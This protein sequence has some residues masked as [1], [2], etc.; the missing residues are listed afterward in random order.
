MGNSPN[1][2]KKRFPW[3]WAI[4]LALGI[5]AGAFTWVQKHAPIALAVGALGSWGFQHKQRAD[6][7]AAAV[8]QR[9]LELRNLAK[10]AAPVQAKAAQPA[11]TPV[12]APVMAKNVAAPHGKA[13]PRPDG[14]LVLE[15]KS[16]QT[17]S[18]DTQPVKGQ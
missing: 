5:L 1:K 12:P 8:V 7:L 2:I 10:T 11:P 16:Y 15:V 18:L 14:E 3:G 13:K 6:A 9:D 4:L 17:P